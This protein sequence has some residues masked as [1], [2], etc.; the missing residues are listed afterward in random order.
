MNCETCKIGLRGVCIVVVK[1]GLVAVSRRLDKAREGLLQFPGGKVETGEECLFAAQ[2]ELKEETGL[3]L[4]I[5]RFTSL[6]SCQPAIG[7]CGESYTA[8]AYLVTLKPDEHL[9][10]NPEPDKH[11]DWEWVSPD[12]LIDAKMLPSSQIAL[13]KAKSFL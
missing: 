10:Q 3:E 12:S 5:D 13:A 9:P 2:R 6:R 8:C 11:T 1:N 4:L 7:F